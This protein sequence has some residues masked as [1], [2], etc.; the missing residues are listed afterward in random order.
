M[1][2]APAAPAAK[3]SRKKKSESPPPNPAIEEPIVPQ[4]TVEPALVEG[5]IEEPAAEIPS[6]EPTEPAVTEPILPADIAS[7]RELIATLPA[8]DVLRVVTKDKRATAQLFAGFR[9]GTDTVRRAIVVQRIAEAAVKVPKL[10]AELGALTADL[11][12][13]PP[14]PSRR[15]GGYQ[16]R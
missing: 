7:W 1:S 8:K 11:T 10:A 3:A 16:G 2:S 15:G 5:P 6:P 9:A 12:P 14:S 4:A 13:R